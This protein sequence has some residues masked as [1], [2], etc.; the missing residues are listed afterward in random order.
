VSRL[1]GV[2]NAVIYYYT[3]QPSDRVSLN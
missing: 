3:N 2:S 1:A